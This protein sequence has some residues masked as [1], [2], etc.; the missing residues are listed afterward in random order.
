MFISEFGVWGLNIIFTGFAIIIYGTA[1]LTA[2]MYTHINTH[3]ILKMAAC[4]SKYIS[5]RELGISA[6]L[7]SGKFNPCQANIR[8]YANI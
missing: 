1:L 7:T 6:I 8:R 4:G 2:Y 5:W 3:G